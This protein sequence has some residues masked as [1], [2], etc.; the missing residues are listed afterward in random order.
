MEAKDVAP[1]T[2]AATTAAVP[3]A[4]VPAPASQSQPLPPATSN[5][6]AHQPPP[7]PFAHHQPP[8]PLQQ[9]QPA[10][11]SANPSAPMPGSGGM[12][13]S[14]DQVVGKAAPGQHH[15]APGPMLYAAPP[16][17]AAGAPVRP[18]GGVGMG[19]GD[20]MRKKRGRPRKYAPDGSMALALAPL[21]SASGG[22]PMQPG[23][24][25]QQ[26]HGGFSISSPPSDPNAKRRGRPP[27]SGKKKQF[28][29]LGSW[30]ISFTPHILSVKAG[31]DVASKI[32]S[33]SQQ[34]PRTVC[35]L[36]ANGAISNVTLRQP[37]TS[38]G[39]VTYEGRFEIISLSG[40]FLLAED[41]DTRSRTG[42]LSVALAGSDGRVLGGCVA[43]QLTAATPVQVVVASFIAEG[44]KS[45]LA[46]ARKVEP[47]SAPPQMA[48]YVPAPVASPPSEGTSSASSDDSGSPINHGGMPYNHSGQHQHPQQQQQHMPPAYASGGWSHSAH[49]QNNN[50]HDG[51]VKMMS[52]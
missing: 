33:F 1:L 31:E 5:A 14:F 47:M 12:R 30:G 6:H 8:P 9:Q 16:P 32:M 45:K 51:D 22:S 52:N 11:G 18:Q 36:S 19:M 20:M 41:G 29:A 42:G 24:Q 38:G 28:E 43:G 4:P 40:S 35:I 46:E 37:A 50:R 34:G 10:P 48:N 49:H 3:A 39:L 23:Q 21:S 44:K 13:L 17:H 26:Q 27:G 25:Q 7:H 2:T 15:H